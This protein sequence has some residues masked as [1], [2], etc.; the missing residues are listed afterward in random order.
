MARCKTANTL[1]LLQ[2]CTKPLT[3]IWTWW[4]HVCMAKM[5]ICYVH[6]LQCIPIYLKTVPIHLRLGVNNFHPYLSGIPM[7]LWLHG[8]YGLYGPRCPL[9]QKR[10]LNLIIHSLTF[11]DTS[12]ALGQ[13]YML[14]S[15]RPSDAIW[16]HRS[17]SALADGT[18]PLPEP[19]LT[20]HQ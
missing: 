5:W 7:R 17:G 8:L 19:T 12:L 11:R 10:L 1:E 16:R 14:N 9:S 20:Y 4:M 6:A 2:Y 18:K 3:C 13:S 15:L